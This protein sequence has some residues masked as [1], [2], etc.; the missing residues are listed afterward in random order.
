MTNVVNLTGEPVTQADDA[1]PQPN[2][3]VVELAKELLR[4]AESGE[5]VGFA[6]VG[7]NDDEGTYTFT[8]GFQTAALLGRLE[9]MKFNIMRDWNDLE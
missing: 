9:H 8:G 3:N 1:T 4:M 7:V 6:G 5:L 2:P